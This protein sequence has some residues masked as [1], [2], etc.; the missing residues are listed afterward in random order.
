MCASR[1]LETHC[2]EVGINSIQEHLIEKSAKRIKC[3]EDV[4]VKTEHFQEE[5]EA[6]AMQS[7]RKR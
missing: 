1:H 7:K 6:D 5:L 3:E 4:A 2:N